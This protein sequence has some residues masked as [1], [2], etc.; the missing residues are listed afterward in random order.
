MR[1]TT[2]IA[3]A[4]AVTVT[5]LAAGGTA[6]A[7]AP[8]SHSSTTSAAVSQAAVTRSQ[9]VAIAKKRVPGARVTE[10]EREWEHGHR[11]WKVELRKGHMEYKVYVAIATGR[12]VKFRAEHDD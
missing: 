8:A 4:A 7:A 2:K 12:I 1:H 3:L 9:A 6:V 5:A 10:I 11:T